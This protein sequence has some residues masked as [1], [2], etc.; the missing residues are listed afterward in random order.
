MSVDIDLP[1][2]LPGQARI[3]AKHRARERDLERDAVVRPGVLVQAPDP[4][5][6]G[7]AKK[8]YKS[9]VEKHP[10]YVETG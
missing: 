8:M 9:F 6:L 2:V 1:D 3:P 7:P 4:G 5:I 10:E